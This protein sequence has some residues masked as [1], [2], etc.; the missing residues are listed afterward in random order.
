MY[1]QMAQPTQ[2]T[3]QPTRTEAELTSIFED[4]AS[5]EDEADNEPVESEGIE[6]DEE[7]TESEQKKP[8]ESRGR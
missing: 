7:A 4:E 3:H 1:P 8:E 5:F 2:S 6:S